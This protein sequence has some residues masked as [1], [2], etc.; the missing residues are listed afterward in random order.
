MIHQLRCLNC[1]CVLQY[2]D[3]LV[4]I[5][6]IYTG[7]IFLTEIPKQGS[8]YKTNLTEDGS[9]W[10]YPPQNNFNSSNAIRKVFDQRSFSFDD[11]FFGNGLDGVNHTTTFSDKYGKVFILR[12][13]L[14]A[15]TTEQETT[16]GIKLNPS[17]NF[18]MVDAE[19]LYF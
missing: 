5:C 8:I 9:G 15:I 19:I 18:F 6:F 1:Q 12:P 13:G 17:L 2:L 7:L 3:L 10:I 16:L 4:H 14:G 11:I